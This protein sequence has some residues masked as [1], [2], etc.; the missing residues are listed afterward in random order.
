MIVEWI[1]VRTMALVLI[2]FMT[3]VV[4][5]YQDLLV[6]HVTMTFVDVMIHSVEILVLAIWVLMVMLNV[7]VIKSIQDCSVKVVR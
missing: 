6:E 7:I 4:N 3:I 1:P 5:V 2:L